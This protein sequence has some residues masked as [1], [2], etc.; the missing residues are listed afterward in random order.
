[1][2]DQRKV[3]K[4]FR[5]GDRILVSTRPCTDPDCSVCKTM[6]D[7]PHFKHNVRVERGQDDAGD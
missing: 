7:V 6:A 3:V 4:V 5:N 1:M 2:T